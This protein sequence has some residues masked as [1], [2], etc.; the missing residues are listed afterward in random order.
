[1]EKSLEPAKHLP[2]NAVTGLTEQERR[3]VQRYL[4]KGEVTEA[5]RFAGYIQPQSMGYKLVER[6]DIESYIEQLILQN[7]QQALAI[8][9]KELRKI[10]ARPAPTAAD[11]SVKVTAI[12]TL[13]SIVG[14]AGKRRD[15]RQRRGREAIPVDKLEAMLKALEAQR[16]RELSTVDITPTQAIDDAGD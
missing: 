6:R 11:K 12:K 14:D 4:E 3:F 8:G 1:M 16:A 7:A 15:E 13:Q 5:A 2:P 9:L 10:V